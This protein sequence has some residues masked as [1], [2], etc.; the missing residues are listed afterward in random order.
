MK[1]VEILN[2]AGLTTKTMQQVV[3]T[4]KKKEK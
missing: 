4:Y 1:D 2:N 3:K